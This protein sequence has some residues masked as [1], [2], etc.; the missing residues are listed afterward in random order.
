M[1]SGI[2]GDANNTPA[3]KRM[4]VGQVHENERD[5]STLPVSSPSNS[6]LGADTISSKSQEKKIHRK[7]RLSDFPNRIEQM[8]RDHDFMF[9]AEFDLINESSATLPVDRSSLT[10]TTDENIL[11][12]RFVNILPY[13]ENRVILSGK[14]DFINASFI[15]GYKQPKEY[16]ATQ[17]PISEEEEKHGQRTA[18]TNDF[19][20]MIWQYNCASVIMLTQCVESSRYKCGQ[21]WPK[22][23]FEAKQYGDI[24]VQL[25]E[26]TDRTICIVRKFAL[27]K[28]EEARTV[29]QWHFMEWKDANAPNARHLLDFIDMVRKSSKH[30]KSPTIV[31]GSGGVGRPGT[32]IALDCLLQHICHHD[33]VDLFACVR[34]LRSQRV[35]MVQTLEQYVAL[36]DCLA[37]AM[38]KGTTEVD[39]GANEDSLSH[40]SI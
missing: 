31:H 20:A 37:V 2:V 25:V 18:T 6:T 34:G 7:I 5:K 8:H 30:F 10:A 15:D 27:I 39:H 29:T 22:N 12:N 14:S 36:H 24:I 35:R 3:V 9:Q 11:K 4:D 23:V 28:N 38:K 19:W 16:I 40:S 33:E 17:G 1:E 21:Y 26:E 13:E 32:Y